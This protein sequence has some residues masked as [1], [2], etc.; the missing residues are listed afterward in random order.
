MKNYKARFLRYCFVCGKRNKTVNVGEKYI[1]STR[2]NNF[3]KIYR[4]NKCKINTTRYLMYQSHNRLYSTFNSEWFYINSDDYSFVTRVVR[5]S[6][7]DDY[8]C[9]LDKNSIFGKF[10]DIF[11]CI[12][13]YFINKDL[14]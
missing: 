7:K 13:K 14:F 3:Y 6:F 12:K 9:K 5:S 2:I 4:C 11:A 10:T 8:G 1:S